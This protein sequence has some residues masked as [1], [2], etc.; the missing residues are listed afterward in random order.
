AHPGPGRRHSGRGDPPGRCGGCDCGAGARRQRRAAA[1]AGHR[2]GRNDRRPSP[3]ADSDRG[4][5]G[6]RPSGDTS[7]A[8]RRPSSRSPSTRSP[9]AAACRPCA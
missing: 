8:S 1:R 5:P 9:V 3:N 6:R 7:T 4:S 2:T